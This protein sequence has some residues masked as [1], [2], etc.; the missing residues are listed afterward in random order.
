M[1]V[2]A[3]RQRR[4]TGVTSNVATGLSEGIALPEFPQ[5]TAVISFACSFQRGHAVKACLSRYLSE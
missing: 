5:I 4:Y 3:A 1:M 2:L